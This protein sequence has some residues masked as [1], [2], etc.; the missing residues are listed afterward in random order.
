MA[1]L[2]IDRL[3]LGCEVDAD[4]PQFIAKEGITHMLSVQYGY[5]SKHK[6]VS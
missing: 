6:E 3:F 4:D 2:I 5:I 1:N